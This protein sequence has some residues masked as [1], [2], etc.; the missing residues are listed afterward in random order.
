MVR[1]LFMV[2]PGFTVTGITVTGVAGKA[3]GEK[4]A[5]RGLLLAAKHPCSFREAAI[6]RSIRYDV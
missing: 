1:E 4:P 6:G 2:R 5:S 3:A